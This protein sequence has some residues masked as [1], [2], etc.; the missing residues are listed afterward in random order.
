MPTLSLSTEIQA[1]LFECELQGQI[2]DGFWENAKPYDHYL[3]W[4][5]DVEVSDNVG[6]NFHVT[7]DNY[8]FNSTELLSY[9]GDRMLQYARVCKVLGLEAVKELRNILNGGS[10]SMPIHTGEYYDKLRA[11]L[12]KYDMDTIQNIANDDSVYN[13]KALRKDLKAIKQQVRIFVR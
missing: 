2:S 7:K 9:V 1:A 12:S 6:R 8:N 13:M 10:V 11:R 5:C 4:L 3:P